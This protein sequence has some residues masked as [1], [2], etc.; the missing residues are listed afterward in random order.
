M[1]WW[2]NLL[3]GVWNGLSAWVVLIA[4]AIDIAKG[5]DPSIMVGVLTPKMEAGQ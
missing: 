5:V 3:W 1:E 4:H 2:Q